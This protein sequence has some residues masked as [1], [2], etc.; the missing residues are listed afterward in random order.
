MKW[1]LTVYWNRAFYF[2]GYFHII[3]GFVRC[4]TL[5]NY[6]RD[7]REWHMTKAK[8]RSWTKVYIWSPFSI[9]CHGTSV[10]QHQ[11]N[12]PVYNSKIEFQSQCWSHG[13]WTSMLLSKKPDK[14]LESTRW[15]DKYVVCAIARWAIRMPLRHWR[16]LWWHWY[17]I[18][19][20]LQQCFGCDPL[21]VRGRA[22]RSA[23]SGRSTLPLGR[24]SHSWPRSTAPAQSYSA[25]LYRVVLHTLGL[26]RRGEGGKVKEWL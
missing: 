5:E 23:R 9:G 25:P 10:Q 13:R 21:V 4:H 7:G 3:S 1:K 16:L 18:V 26:R 14:D 19:S 2:K 12:C 6:R 20:Y 11:Q 8:S 17:S 24:P 15:F 22:K